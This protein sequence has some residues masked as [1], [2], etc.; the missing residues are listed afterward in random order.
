M[1][2]GST[3]LIHAVAGGMGQ[4]LTRWSKELGATVIGTVSNPDKAAL[5]LAAGADHVIDYS[6]ED[7]AAETLRFTS[8]RGADL[9]VDGVG[10]T[11]LREEPGRG[12]DAR[13]DHSLRLRERRSGALRPAAIDGEIGDA[14]R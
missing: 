7:F 13:P 1:E 3:V 11:E 14:R 2:S 8:G 10:K 4:L 12:G 5:A 9:V 6:R